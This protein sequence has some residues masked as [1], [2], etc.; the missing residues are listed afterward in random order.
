M[1]R[2]RL[3]G[4]ER[5]DRGLRLTYPAL[6]TAKPPNGK[7]Q[8]HPQKA[9]ATRRAGSKSA[10]RADGTTRLGASID[11]GDSVAAWNLPASGASRPQRVPAPGSAAGPVGWA[12]MRVTHVDAKDLLASDR[13][14]DGL[15]CTH[16]RRS[17]DGATAARTPPLHRGVDPVGDQAL[18]RADTALTLAPPASAL[19]SPGEAPNPHRK[20]YIR[21]PRH[22]SNVRP[23][24]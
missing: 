7:A 2:P 6:F 21:C 23:S 24:D 10:S 14:A 17:H 8:A 9:L 1:R 19:P 15:G 20:P 22:D 11:D 12:G 18:R 3:G 5:G 16:A 13:A 4:L